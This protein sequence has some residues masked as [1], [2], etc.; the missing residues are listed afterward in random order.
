MNN[1]SGISTNTNKTLILI[2]GVIS[3]VL[4]AISIKTLL[5]YVEMLSGGGIL[6]PFSCAMN[7]I[8]LLFFLLLGIA[9]LVKS[10]ALI[11][12]ALI[13]N[14]AVS[15]IVLFQNILYGA[16]LFSIL[17]QLVSVISKTLLIL[18]F[19]CITVNPRSK[20]TSLVLGVLAAFFFL[21]T[22]IFMI[23]V[24]STIS[25]TTHISLSLQVVLYS[26]LAFAFS[27]RVKNGSVAAPRVS[28]PA[29]P[30]AP[31]SPTNNFEQLTKLKE[32]LDAGI[33]TE[34]EFSAKKKE[35]FG[36]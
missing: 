12:T 33:I 23:A 26:F 4:F 15:F 18:S 2:A 10:N 8:S 32:L 7:I 36:L 17:R 19:V 9:L 31:A 22:Y 14:F 29:A 11:L 6:A 28:A 21:L 25:Y 24:S 27:S 16:S 35:L 30:V 1:T 3:L 20:R 34:E 13:I 5:F